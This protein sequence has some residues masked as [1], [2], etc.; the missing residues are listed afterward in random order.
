VLFQLGSDFMIDPMHTAYDISPDDRRFMMV[1]SV[2]MPE[3][4]Q[5]RL[6]VVDNFYEWLKDK[7]GN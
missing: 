1:R 5:P 4:L 3:T 2:A 6:V 7:V